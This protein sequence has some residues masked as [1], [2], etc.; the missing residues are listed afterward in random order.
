M[1]TR[2]KWCK[3]SSARSGGG[4]ELEDGELEDGEGLGCKSSSSFSATTS[5]DMEDAKDS[6][7]I[8][9]GRDSKKRWT[10]CLVGLVRT[11]AAE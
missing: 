2:W 5:K 3:A 7:E 10:I 1:V 11:G 6:V 9:S 4:E 8:R